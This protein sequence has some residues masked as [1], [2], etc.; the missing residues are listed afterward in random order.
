MNINT[1]NG[2][3]EKSTGKNCSQRR[4]IT[5]GCPSCYKSYGDPQLRLNEPGRERETLNKR[6]AII[7]SLREQLVDLDAA[8]E[9]RSSH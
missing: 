8:I 2:P 4:R 7:N 5:G 9:T 6:K 1:K 3:C